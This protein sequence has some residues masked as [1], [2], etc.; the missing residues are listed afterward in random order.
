M[1]LVIGGRSKIGSSLIDSLRARGER[2]RALVRA[3]ESEA[4]PLAGVDCVVGDLADPASL[5]T[6][7]AETDRVSLLS[8]PHRDAVRWHQNAIDA[9]RAA[10]VGLLVRSSIIGASESSP[11]EFVRPTA[12]QRR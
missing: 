7:M 2:V 6:A 8:S 3:H 9:A 11:A 5:R 12:T 10:G 4:A 1:I